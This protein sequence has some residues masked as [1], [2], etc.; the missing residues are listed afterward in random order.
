MSTT[1]L[2]VSVTSVLISLVTWIYFVCT[3]NDS[4]EIN[5]TTNWNKFLVFLLSLAL[6]GILILIA[7]GLAVQKLLT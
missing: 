7:I 2:I 3:V 5:S 4:C 6:T 1:I